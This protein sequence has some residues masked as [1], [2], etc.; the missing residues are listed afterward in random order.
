VNRSALALIGAVAACTVASAAATVEY[1]EIFPSSGA[2]DRPI[3]STGWTAARATT[4][5][6]PVTLGGTPLSWRAGKPADAIAVNSAPEAQVGA[7]FLAFDGAT[8]GNFLVYTEEHPFS[9]SSKPLDSISW[10]QGNNYNSAYYMHA[11]L[12]ISGTWYAS[13]NVATNPYVSGG[14]DFSDTSGTKNSAV[15]R[16][17]DMASAT[18]TTVNSDYTVGSAASLPT[19][20]TVEAVGILTSSPNQYFR[21]DTFSVSVV[22]E[23]TL[24]LA[25]AGLAMLA[26]GRRRRLA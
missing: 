15:L 25:L 12:K 4:G 24:G 21:F 11:A 8:G 2:V 9:L 19:T 18:W 23:P 7:G 20:G 13:N 16:T 1:Q 26:T 10:Y 14:A 3:T 22:P 17:V 5:G 6:L